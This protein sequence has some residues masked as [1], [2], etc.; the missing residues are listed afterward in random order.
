M[1]TTACRVFRRPTS[2]KM[3]VHSLTQQTPNPDAHFPFGDPFT[4]LHCVLDGS[5]K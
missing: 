1:N 5:K 4:L 3:T 2:A